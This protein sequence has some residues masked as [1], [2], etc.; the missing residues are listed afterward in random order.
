[1]KSSIGNEDENHE[2]QFLLSQIV[3]DS[4]NDTTI[5]IPASILVYQKDAIGRK[6]S[7]FDGLIIHPMRKSNQVIFLA[8]K[9][10]DK[11]PNFGKKC[12]MEKFSKFSFKYA[13]DTIEIVGYDAFWKY[14]IK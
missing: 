8:A 11:K 12:L 10:R 2:V 6:L 4:T 3:D 9:N 14:S 1:M 13:P 7:E 5:T